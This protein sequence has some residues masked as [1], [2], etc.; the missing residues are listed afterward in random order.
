MNRV[1]GATQPRRSGALPGGRR[2]LNAAPVGRLAHLCLGPAPQEAAE[3]LGISLKTVDSHKTA[4]LGECRVV[5]VIPDNARLD[6]HFL[7]DKFGPMLDDLF[8]V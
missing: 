2:T 3:A 7:H 4:I 1:G 5:W 8:P 6:Y